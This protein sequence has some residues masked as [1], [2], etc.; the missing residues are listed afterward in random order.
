MNMSDFVDK[1]RISKKEAVILII[2]F[3]VVVFIFFPRRK[4]LKDGGTTAY[5]SCFGGI[6]YTV[7][8]RHRLQ[9]D[10]Y[11]ENG[12]VIYIAG[13]EVYN[14][15]SIDYSVPAETRSSDVESLMAEIDRTV[16]SS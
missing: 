5:D 12:I 13:I 10:G 14:D 1:K 4:T 6:I 7:E 2:L 3:L 11:Y 9:D 16:Y 15:S 8:Q